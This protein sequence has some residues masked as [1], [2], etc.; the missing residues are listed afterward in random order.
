MK[1]DAAVERHPVLHRRRI[2]VSLQHCILRHGKDIKDPIRRAV[3]D[4]SLAGD[5]VAVQNHFVV[6]DDINMLIVQIHGHIVPAPVLIAVFLS[7][8]LPDR[9]EHREGSFSRPDPGTAADP[10]FRI[11]ADDCIRPGRG[12]LPAI[13]CVKCR[14]LHAIR[15]DCCSKFLRRGLLIQFP[16][17]RPGFNGHSAVTPRIREGALL[18]DRVIFFRQIGDV[19]RN[20][21]LPDISSTVLIF[22]PGQQFFCAGPFLLIAEAQRR[23]FIQYPVLRIRLCGERRIV[24]AALWFPVKSR[25]IQIQ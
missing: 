17:K 18:P 10:L 19:C 2:A 23:K 24:C 12:R 5:A 3:S 22:D 6:L 9:I 14:I 15:R 13:R 7:H 11:H 4:H 8:L 21:I 25:C 16:S 20:L 1:S